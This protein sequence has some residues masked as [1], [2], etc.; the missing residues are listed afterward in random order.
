MASYNSKNNLANSKVVL[1]L[2]NNGIY[3]VGVVFLVPYIVRYFK[4]QEV[5]DVKQSLDLAVKTNS[6][7]N[8]KVDPTI[9]KSKETSLK[10]KYPNLSAKDSTRLKTIAQSIAF[11]LGTNPEGSTSVL[12]VDLYGVGSWVE[13]EKEV[14]KQLK[15]TTGTFPIVEDYYYHLFTRS[16]NLKTDLYKYLSSSDL[17]T[18]RTVYK[19]A[20]KSWL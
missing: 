18:L 14:V 1:F 6:A 16:R 2:K 3:L 17:T 10:K 8:N 19:K 11:A 7:Q 15:T 4:S 20:G 12:N 13:D 5:K 9:I